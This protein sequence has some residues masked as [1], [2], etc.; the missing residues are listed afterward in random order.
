MQQ[1][2]RVQDEKPKTENWVLCMFNCSQ[3]IYNGKVI[4]E[5]KAYIV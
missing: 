4:T 1:A 5:E 3:G 2:D